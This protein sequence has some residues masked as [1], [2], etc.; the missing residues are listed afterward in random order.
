VAQGLTNPQ[1]VASFDAAVSLT[2]KIV[3]DE[4]AGEKVGDP[5]DVVIDGRLESGSDSH[6]FFTG[7]SQIVYGSDDGGGTVVSIP[8]LQPPDYVGMNTEGSERSSTSRLQTT[9]GQ[10]FRIYADMTREGTILPKVSFYGEYCIMSFHVHLAEPQGTDIAA[11]SLTWD[12]KQ[13]GVNF[14]YQITN[15]DLPTDMTVALYW[16]KGTSWDDVIDKSKP[17]YIYNLNTPALKAKGTPPPIHVA[18]K[19]L[20]IPP[21]GT[22]HLLVVADPP[23]ATHSTGLVKESDESNNVLA[24]DGSLTVEQLRAIMPALPA[25]KA[26]LFLEPLK[27]AMRQFSIN[28]YARSASFLSQVALESDQLRHWVEGVSLT[29]KVGTKVG[30]G[31]VIMSTPALYE[32]KTGNKISTVYVSGP[33]FINYDSLGPAPQRA[34]LLG[35]TQPGDGPMFRGRG[36]IQV[37]GRTRYRDAGKAL[38]LD[39]LSHP[40]RVGDPDNHA[41]VGFQ[42]AGWFW[43]SRNINPVADAVNIKDDGSIVQTNQRV[44][45]L[46]NGGYNA[47]DLRL[48]SYRKAL[49]FLL[50]D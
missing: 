24:L 2:V 27:A 13:G 18:R 1:G 44:T 33:N 19:E 17:A 7:E 20:G 32:V 46:V 11:T 30:A 42:V 25:A 16:A 41:L 50:A 38:G 28:T 12:P 15:G 3:S 45:L 39:L 14:A 37:T 21:Q 34:Q 8:S 22:T 10:T 40:E 9:I 49:D 48:G 4:A 23:D 35:N 29:K 43:K 5:I 47:I 26:Q 36:P 6:H 31:I